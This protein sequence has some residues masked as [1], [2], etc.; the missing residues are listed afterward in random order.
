MPHS[1]PQH[2]NFIPLDSVRANLEAFGAV[3]GEAAYPIST[4]E[5]LD[6]VAAFEA[7]AKAVSAEG[8]ISK[9]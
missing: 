9:V 1:L 4:S 5:M 7:I 2:L 8:R 3:S 6:T